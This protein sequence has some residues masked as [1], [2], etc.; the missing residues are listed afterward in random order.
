MFDPALFLA[1][2]GAASI[3]TF[4]PGVDTAMALRR[5]D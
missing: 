3:L 5:R 2:I 4:T 1:F